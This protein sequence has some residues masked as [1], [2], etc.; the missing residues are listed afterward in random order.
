MHPDYT[1]F[2]NFRHLAH[3]RSLDKPFKIVMYA[4]W[5]NKGWGQRYEQLLPV[6]LT[7]NA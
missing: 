4:N 5:K 6:S 3:F 7:N 2:A 1:S